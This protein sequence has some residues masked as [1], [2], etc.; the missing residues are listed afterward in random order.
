MTLRTN[1][2]WGGA[3]AAHQY[4]GAYLED[5]KGLCTFDA[6]GGGSYT[7]RRQVTYMDE[8]GQVGVAAVDSS[9]T[10]PVPKQTRGYVDP[11]R[12]YPSHEATDFYH[13][14]KEDIALMAQMGFKC[15]RM[16]IA[17]TRICP[18]G[19]EEINE[20]GLAFYDQIF[21][22]L[23]KYGIEPVVTLNHFDMPMY[24]AD[25]WDGWLSRKVVDYFLFFCETVFKRYRGKVKYWMTFNEINV[26]SSWCQ[27]GVHENNEAN[28]AQ[29]HHHILIASAKAVQLG[30]HIDPHNQ[31]GM[32]VSYTP[33]YP[34]TCKPED[35]LE[36]IQFNRQKEFYMDVQVRGYYPE[37]RCK[38][39]E[40]KH[41]SIA[42]AKDDLAILKAGTVDFIGFSY[43]MSTV[44]GTD[45]KVEKTQGN[46]FLGLKNPY[47]ETSDW[48][49]TV[50]P[51]GL[52]IALI[53]MYER[54]HLPLFVVENGLGAKDTV[55]ESGAI[56][57]DYRIAYLRS[58][59]QALKDA[60]RLDGVD[61]MGYTPWGCID[62]ISAG[63]GEMAKR[64][65]L[66]YVD[67]HDDGSGDLSRHPKK[68]FRWYQQVIRTNGEEL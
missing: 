44:A 11:N 40:R 31:I 42:M 33:C 29:A 63:T 46:Q 58:H 2:L 48:G 32:M 17:W 24:L 45:S 30:H 68:S 39:L 57:D 6:L 5:G 56:N 49:W 59:I 13:H 27:T 47:L 4:E 62:I 41:I 61:V 66:V 50:D 16:S 21:D 52:R 10:G 12:Y 43:Y 36:A 28:L 23:R 15:Y 64:Y 34:L 67:K 26:L 54:Y 51:L 20:A 25:H 18:K 37:Y 60:V 9:M 8:K 1:F 53:Q 22:E 55:E 7:E 35:V 3:S 14:W 65:G 19:T 38:E